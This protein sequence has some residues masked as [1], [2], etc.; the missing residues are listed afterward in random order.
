MDVGS[1]IRGIRKELGLSLEQLS[2]KCGVALATLSRIE[3]DKGSSTFRTHQRI[4]EALN[5]PIADLYKGLEQQSHEAILVAPESEDPESFTYDEK[6]S[7]VLLTKQVS[8][9][10]MLPQMIILQPFGKTSLEQY[11]SLSERWLL[12][13]EGTVEAAVGGKNYRLAP[14]NTLYFKASLPHQIMNTGT[15][16]AKIISVTSPAVL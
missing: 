10:Q 13:S 6:S 1:R 5:V 14:G 15:S 4:A 16:T 8:G 12:V 7:A 9:K 11:P 2:A 3:N